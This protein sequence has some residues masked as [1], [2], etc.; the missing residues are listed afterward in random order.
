MNAAARQ[1]MLQPILDTRKCVACGLCAQVCGMDVITR[2]GDGRPVI[3]R[4]VYCHACGHC[5]AL[6]PQ[7]ALSIPGLDVD[8]YAPAP[9]P[10]ISPADMEAFLLTKRSCREFK[11]RP[12]EKPVIEQLLAVA[13]MAP[14]AINCQER[15][16]IVVTDRR[17]IAELRAA[18]TQ[19]VRS[20]LKLV[21]LAA[22]KPAALLLPAETQQ[23]M[24]HLQA[25]FEVALRHVDAGEDYIFHNASCLIF[26]AGVAKDPAGKD[27]ALGAQHY[28][29]L[30]AETLGLGTCINGY[31]QSAP[32]VLSR[33]LNVPKGYTLYGALMLGYRKHTYQKRVYRKPASVVYYE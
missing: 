29:M 6:C 14:T 27:H 12:V 16:F 21:K 28:L 9:T 22:G 23:Y 10:A 25:D 11:D 3:H 20:V 17:K 18:L 24:R 7:N 26:F 30:Y 32:K 19:H 15:A 1:D 13:R 8:E 33:C 4:D 5:V 2:D 31:A